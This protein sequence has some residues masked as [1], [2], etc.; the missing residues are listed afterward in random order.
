MQIY[1]KGL[2]YSKNSTENMV[3]RDDYM[4]MSTQRPHSWEQETVNY[5]IMW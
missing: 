2:S 5:K 3:T 1:L 4:V